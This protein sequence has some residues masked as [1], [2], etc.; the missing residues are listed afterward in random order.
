MIRF[1]CLLVLLS[2]APLVLVALRTTGSNA[3]VFSFVGAP[4][5]AAGVLVYGFQRWR[6]GA[7]APSSR[8]EERSSR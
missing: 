5:L 3:I 4:L 2:L 8:Q 6:E 1:A 7:F